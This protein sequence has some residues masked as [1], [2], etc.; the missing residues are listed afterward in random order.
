MTGIA[1]QEWAPPLDPP[2]TGGLPLE[3]AQALA[4]AHWDEDPHLCSA[5]QWEAYAALLPPTPTVAQ[6]ATGQQS[7]SYSPPMPG[8]EYGTALA[9]A[10]W[11]RSFLGTL[12]SAPLRVAWP[13]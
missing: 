12:H 8:G 1:W 9:R 13:H 5:L 7:V 10:A 6:V 3:A 2:A 11:H 4:D